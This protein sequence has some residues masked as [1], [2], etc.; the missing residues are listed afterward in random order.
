[1]DPST[2]IEITTLE[3]NVARLQQQIE[4]TEK[5]L[6]HAWLLIC[7]CLVFMM[8]AGFSLL[9][10]GGVRAKNSKNILIKNVLDCSSSGLA[11]FLVGWAIAF[12]GGSDANYFVGNENFA[13]AGIEDNMLS[14]WFF[15]WSF[16]ATSVTIVSG[17]VAERCSF[18]AY[19]IFSFLMTA[20]TYPCGAHWIWS[21]KA[22][23]AD[24]HIL[25]LRYVDFA[26]SS[27][28]HTTGGAA[29]LVGA[30]MLGPRIGR[31]SSNGTVN[32]MPGHNLVLSTLGMFL[33]W[34]GWFGFNGG[35]TLGL[36]NNRAVVAAKT[37]VNTALA[38]SAGGGMVALYS[39]LRRRVVDLGPILN[40]VLGSLVA[41]TAGCFAYDEWA[42]VLIGAIAGLIYHGTTQ[43]L[44][45]LRIDDPLEAVSVHLA[46]GAWGILALGLFAHE[47]DGVTGIFFGNPSQLASQVV[48]LC[49][50]IGWTVFTS[51]VFFAGIR[52]VI[53]L[54]IPRTAE[55]KGV[56]YV[57]HGGS[58]YPDFMVELLEKTGPPE[59]SA[60]V[61]LTDVEGSTE[62]WAWDPELM[63]LAMKQHDTILREALLAFH[64]YEFYTEGDAFFMAFH[65]TGDALQWCLTVQQNLVNYKWPPRLMEHRAWV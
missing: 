59:G 9:E 63:D 60:V 11:W 49:V 47:R 33:L 8:Q 42:S 14:T 35:S 45:K 32:P 19:V 57:K 62:L 24:G 21:K 52:V 51:W 48:G 22:W 30:W 25:G 12:G 55:R 50:M 34:V 15:Q 58:A 38:G 23:M 5:A 29:G 39:A 13:S 54:R 56:D 40:G 18:E 43:L 3:A 36:S 10:V 17:S 65:T 16:A 7:G 44:L 6:D 46:C 4:E 41:V 1:M 28:V 2:E 53:G 37:M 20:V 64:G 27:V 31:F 61:V 26:G